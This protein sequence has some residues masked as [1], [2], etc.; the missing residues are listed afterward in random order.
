MSVVNQMLRDLEQRRTNSP[1]ASPLQGLSLVGDPGR[2][3]PSMNYALAGILLVFTVFLAVYFS[4]QRVRV[5]DKHDS[6]IDPRTVQSQPAPAIDSNKQNGTVLAQS[7]PETDSPVP[8]PRIEAKNPLPPA[9]DTKPAPLTTLAGN[10]A[11][12]K[13]KPVAAAQ[14]PSRTSKGVARTIQPVAPRSSKK[15]QPTPDNAP[16]SKPDAAPHVE[17]AAQATP[18]EQASPSPVIDMRVRPLTARQRA[19]EKFQLAVKF[20]G[21]GDQDKAYQA[22]ESALS[23]DPA[24]QRARETAAVLLINT[25]RMSEAGALLRQGLQIN[26][27]ASGLAKLYARFLADQGDIEQSIRVLEIAQP[28]VA[29]DA[30]YHALLA[31]FYARM[32][33]H[34]QAIKT[35]RRVLQNHSGEPQW[36]MGLALSLESAGTPAQAL[37]AYQRAQRS[38]RMSPG[39]RKFIAQRV[40][41][42]VSSAGPLAT[43]SDIGED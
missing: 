26:A 19:Q 16:G 25:G 35:Y 30:P 38:G 32:G 42:L 43:G 28:P 41:A 11:A 36:W 7:A 34:E 18:L 5:P 2:P 3:A 10:V 9:T 14:K 13:T 40:Q 29:N 22:L 37:S 27:K 21:R 15:I 24:H 6:A 4:M 12:T 33:R 8:H 20:L 17:V 31:A 1:T 39:I 23:E